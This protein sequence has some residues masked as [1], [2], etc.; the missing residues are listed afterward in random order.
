M[1]R[2]ARLSL[3]REE[4][5]L[6]AQLRQLVALDDLEARVAAQNF[7]ER[8]RDARLAESFLTLQ[9]ALLLAG[10]QHQESWHIA[11]LQ[12]KDGCEFGFSGHVQ[13]HEVKGDSAFDLAAEE[14]LDVLHG[15]DHALVACSCVGHG[16]NH[17]EDAVFL[18]ADVIGA[19]LAEEGYGLG[20]PRTRGSAFDGTLLLF[21]H[22]GLRVSVDELKER[23][24]AKLVLSVADRLLL[25][26]FEDQEGGELCHLVL[27]DQRLIV[28]LD[29]AEFQSFLNK[30]HTLAVSDAAPSAKK[31]V[32][33]G[34]LRRS[35]C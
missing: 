1:S 26:V 17:A 11:L 34:Y 14:V 7:V 33:L 31:R 27:F 23:I 19:L 35:R 2:R 9:E 29:K 22:E 8:V 24:I 20:Q 5:V 6:V 15:G 25:A 28:V 13:T 12:A 10:V 30:S 16:V 32:F 4:G 3:L 21:E 18:Q